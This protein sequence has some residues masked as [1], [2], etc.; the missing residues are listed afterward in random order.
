[1]SNAIY[2]IFY[3]DKDNYFGDGVNTIYLKSNGIGDTSISNAYT[4]N[5]L[6]KKMNPMWNQVMSLED[7]VLKCM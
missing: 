2:R 7:H 6:V 5:T 3:V 1:M 4:T